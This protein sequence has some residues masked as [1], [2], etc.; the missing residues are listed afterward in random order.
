MISLIFLEGGDRT[1]EQGLDDE[2]V[3]VFGPG[4]VVATQRLLSRSYRSSIGASE[5]RG[6]KMP[7]MFPKFC[8][9]SFVVTSFFPSEIYL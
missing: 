9:K 4:G 2:G 3:C 6:E 1:A 5:R 8:Q 7:L